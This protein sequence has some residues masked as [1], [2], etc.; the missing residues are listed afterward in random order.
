MKSEEAC[1]EN[2][3][4]HSEI[5]MAPVEQPKSRSLWFFKLS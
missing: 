1:I 5:A 4:L 3:T 2:L